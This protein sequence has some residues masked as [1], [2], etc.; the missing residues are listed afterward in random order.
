MQGW[1]QELNWEGEGAAKV[2]I[3]IVC[4]SFCPRQYYCHKGDKQPEKSMELNLHTG[5]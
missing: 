1:I 4:K 5:F 2:D 3:I